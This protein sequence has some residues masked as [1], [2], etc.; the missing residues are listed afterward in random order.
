MTM[1]ETP[2]PFDP[3]P[4]PLIEDPPREPDHVPTLPPAHDTPPQE[5]EARG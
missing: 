2:N 5:E 3:G 1:T 4:K